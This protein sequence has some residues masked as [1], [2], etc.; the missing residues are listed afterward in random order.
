MPY[1]LGSIWSQILFRRDSIYYDPS[2]RERAGPFFSLNSDK[3]TDF[4]QPTVIAWDCNWNRLDY[5]LALL[6]IFS[7][8][9]K[10]ISTKTGS[11]SGF[12]KLPAA[13][14]LGNQIIST[15]PEDLLG[16]KSSMDQRASWLQGIFSALKMWSASSMNPSVSFWNKH[17]IMI[18]NLVCFQEEFVIALSTTNSI[19]GLWPIT[20]GIPKRLCTMR[21]S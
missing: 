18:D 8:K 3:S 14:G 4:S 5:L 1:C 2:K 19:H 20:K 15:P 9:R 6:P 11:P 10:T 17:N 7:I 12:E 13:S 16:P 21:K